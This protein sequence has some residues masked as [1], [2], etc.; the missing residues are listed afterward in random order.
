[1][2]LANTHGYRL[3]GQQGRRACSAGGTSAP[4]RLHTPR[5]SG[6]KPARWPDLA[7]VLHRKGHLYVAY[8]VCVRHKI[9]GVFIR[10]ELHVFDLLRRKPWNNCNIGKNRVAVDGGDDPNDD[11]VPATLRNV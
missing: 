6:G 2:S 5:A 9:G 1:M 4:W 8:P 10:L 11:E 3:K 7:T